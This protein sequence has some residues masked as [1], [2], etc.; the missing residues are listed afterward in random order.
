MVKYYDRTYRRLDF[1]IEMLTSWKSLKYRATT[2]KDY[3]LKKYFGVNNIITEQELLALEEFTKASSMV[4]K[5]VERYHLK[6][7]DVEVDLFR[8]NDDKDYKLDQKHLGWKKAALKGVKIHNVTG[9]HLGIVEPPNDKILA[10][11][12]QDILDEKHANI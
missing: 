10:K 3:V 4:D 9:N 2:K 8:A 7:L 11:M 5:I 12:I 1:L 6:P